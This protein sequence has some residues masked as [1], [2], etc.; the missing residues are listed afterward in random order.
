MKKMFCLVLILVTLSTVAYADMDRGEF[1][2]LL[3]VVI[4]K[5]YSEQ[6]PIII[7][8]DRYNNLWSFYDSDDEWQIGDIANCLMWNMGGNIE[9]DEIVE[10]YYEGHIEIS[11]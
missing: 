10:V 6:D 1:Y 2:P 7:C 8:K 3:T 9:E 4:E 11:K 5:D